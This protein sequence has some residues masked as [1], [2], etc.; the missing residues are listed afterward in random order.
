MCASALKKI[1]EVGGGGEGGTY[2]AR[3]RLKMQNRILGG[4]H[5]V[6]QTWDGDTGCLNHG[7]ETQGASIIGWRHRVPH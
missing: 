7:I 4:G 3:F 6:S 5:R 1:R 2:M